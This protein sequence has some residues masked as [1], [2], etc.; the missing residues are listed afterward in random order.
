MARAIEDHGGD[1]LRLHAL[2]LGKIVDV[3][4]GRRVE[5]DDAI[6]ITGAD[7]DLV[8]VDVRRV[9]ERTLFG[10]GDG[11]DGAGHV[12]GAQ[13]G[14]FE[15]IDS[16]VD[17]EPALGADLLADKQHRRFVQ[18]ALADD[19]GAVDRQFVELA[20]HGVHGGLV[21]G[22]FFSAPAQPRRVDRR[23]LGHAYDLHRQNALQ[24]HAVRNGDRRHFLFPCNNACFCGQFFSMRITCGRPEITRSRRTAASA[25]RTASSLVA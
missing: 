17:F 11:C 8:H 4:A 1:G 6:G 5:I 16:N 25:L 22:F 13:S 2:G 19:D 9:Q 12:L 20:P 14:A 24:H 3:F 15:R 23:T 18:L 7:R 10:H 21:G